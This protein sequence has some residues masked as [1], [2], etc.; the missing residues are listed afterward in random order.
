MNLPVSFSEREKEVAA[1]LLQGKSNKQIAQALGVSTRT[2]EF[3]IS[4]IYAKMGVSSR[5]EAIVQL[6]QAN[7]RD[8]TGPD[9]RE[10]EGDLRSPTVD[11]MPEPSENKDEIYGPKRRPPMKKLLLIVLALF[12]GL[13]LI[14]IVGVLLFNLPARQGN[15]AIH[16]STEVVVEVQQPTDTLYVPE[17]THTPI[18]PSPTPWLT[19]TPPVEPPAAVEQPMPLQPSNGRIGFQGVNFALDPA[20]ASGAQ[21]QLVPEQPASADVPGWEVLPQYVKIA[22]E[23][24]P[25]T[26]DN[27]A[28]VVAVYPVDEYRRLSPQVAETLDALQA[29]LAEKPAAP[30][31][32]PVLPPTNAG[33]VFHSNVKYLDFNGG[34]GVRALVLYAQYPAPVNNADLFYTFQGLTGDGRSEVSIILP[35][36]HPSLPADLNSLTGEQMDA[37]TQDYNSYTA[38][39]A[40]DLSAQPDS[41]FT[42]DLS[43]LDALVASLSVGR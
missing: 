20:V 19:P 29:L 27:R 34:S 14:S 37:I 15:G 26:Q 18:Q 41:S 38:N 1:L 39:M 12:A 28:P 23:G 11:K 40:T 33:Q 6:S 36:N 16:Q 17:A 25:V 30:E 2:A 21:G 24:Y 3:H 22:L 9:L 8:S 35:V 32:V 42:P 5:A 43:K 13:C 31:R 10:P 7:L 4:N